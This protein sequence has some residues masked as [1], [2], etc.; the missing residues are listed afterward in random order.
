MEDAA[1]PLQCTF[2]RNRCGRSRA[3]AKLVAAH[4]LPFVRSAHATHIGQRNENQDC[5]AQVSIG[6][7]TLLCLLADGMGVYG[8][9]ISH[10]A[11][12]LT[13]ITC[14][15][16]IAAYPDSRWLLRQ[17]VEH[18]HTYLAAWRRANA[19]IREPGGTTLE[20]LLVQP[21][22]VFLAHSGDSRV[23]LLRGTHLHLLTHDH[24]IP[25]ALLTNG[26]LQP[27]QV[28]NHLYRNYLLRYI[29]SGHKL[30]ADYTEIQTRPYDRLLVCSDGLWSSLIWA[31]MVSHLYRTDPARAVLSLLTLALE[32]GAQDNIS[33]IVIETQQGSI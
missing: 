20:A 33:L 19:K 17:T 31:D 23:F 8:R 10:F 4:A 1:L 27:E 18:L 29:G 13:A 26:S 15:R 30:A 9:S 24:S 16:S 25:G 12:H 22:R 3:I 6:R 11:V 21:G 32:R 2:R 14:A 28:A 5:V 7:N